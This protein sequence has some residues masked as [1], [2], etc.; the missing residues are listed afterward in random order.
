MLAAIAADGLPGELRGAAGVHV[1]LAIAGGT[2]ETG[3]GARPRGFAIDGALELARR[4][5]S[6]AVWVSRSAADFLD[7]SDLLE[8]ATELALPGEPSGPCY[9][10]SESLRSVR[11]P[12]LSG[13]ESLPELGCDMDR[14]PL[15][16]REHELDLLRQRWIRAL[17]GQGQAVVLT[18]EAGIGKSR[19]ASELMREVRGS[20]ARCLECQCAEEDEGRLLRPIEM[21]LE[22][23]LIGDQTAPEHRRDALES[24]LGGLALQDELVYLAT[25][26]GISIEAPAEPPDVLRGRTLDAIIRVLLAKAEERPVAMLVEDLHWSDPTTIE[27]LGRLIEQ[28]EGSAFLLLATTRPELSVPWGPQILSVPLGRLDPAAARKIALAH[29]PEESLSESLIDAIV[30]WTDG[31]PFFVEELVEEVVRKGVR[32]AD[33]LAEL[34][35]P[36]T[37]R[38][39]LGAR[40]DAVGPALETAQLAAALGV[41]FEREWL[42]SLRDPQVVEKDIA[43][44]VAADLV[45]RRLQGGRVVYRFRH[46]LVCEVAYGTM[47]SSTRR[48]AHGAIADLLEEEFEETARRRPDL[49][50]HHRS[51]A[52]QLARAIPHAHAAALAALLRSAS[53]EAAQH[54]R[55]GLSWLEAIPD[56]RARE[57]LELDLNAVLGPAIMATAGLWGPELQAILQRSRELLDRVGDSPHAFP[58]YW[59]VTLSKVLGRPTEALAPARE[60]L[61]IA[62]RGGV[63]VQISAANALVATSH[64]FSGSLREAHVYGARAVEL[65]DVERHGSFVFTSGIDPYVMALFVETHYYYHRGEWERG[66]ACAE[67]A[68][69]A[70]RRLGVAQSV[71]V[72]LFAASVSYHCARDRVAVRRLTD[73]MRQHSADHT[74]A[75]WVQ[76]GELFRGWADD[77]LEGSRAALEMLQAMGDLTQVATW[78]GIVSELEMRAGQHEAAQARLEAW[79]P[80]IEACGSRLDEPALRHIAARIRRAVGDEEGALE[81]LRAAVELGIALDTYVHALRAALEH[82]ELRPGSAEAREALERCLAKLVTGTTLPEAARARELLG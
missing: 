62:E 44:L 33:S 69:G 48:A 57:A 10:L 5:P 14:A 78:H 39:L 60:L 19:L 50:A 63:T 81:Q 25:L 70:A 15:L 41:E 35:I 58:T 55:R 46:A 67:Q 17:D 75:M 82:W 54:A 74:M 68:L 73:E 40:L 52:G 22:R 61:R 30:E 66:L 27:F 36:A 23:E 21:M 11:A 3:D 37:L 2:A 6:G 9:G 31:V 43:T 42:A 79:M 38:G 26:L 49:L 47:V 8:A 28:L 18:G 71:A 77:H 59:I 34:G 72:A 12:G 64:Y 51:A 1:G 65:W 45:R 80:R 13:E 29:H 32:R 20:R 7:T 76:Y 24:A 16:G 53:I 4:A 56:A